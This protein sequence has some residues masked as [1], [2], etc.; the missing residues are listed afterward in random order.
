MRG[1][2]DLY[3]PEVGKG[4]S[5]SDRCADEAEAPRKT[6]EREVTIRRREEGPGPGVARV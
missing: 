2:N 6:S 3:D 5:T 4:V 1:W